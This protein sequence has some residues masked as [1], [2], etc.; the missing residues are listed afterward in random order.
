MDTLLNALIKNTKLA[1]ILIG[2]F[3]IV[4]GASGGFTKL[5]LT[6]A[7]VAW[8]VALFLMGM[9]VAGFGALLIWRT[10]HETADVESIKNAYALKIIWPMVGA[11]VEGHVT[12]KGTFRELP[13]KDS[14]WVLEKSLATGLYYFS[15]NP[16]FDDENRQWNADYTVGGGPG[17]ERLLCV[18]AVGKPGKVLAEYYSK[19]IKDTGQRIGVQD[20][21]ADIVILDSVRLK[22]K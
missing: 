16:I 6:I 19:V 8:R 3:L 12:V 15:R 2:L 10:G 5:S 4:M 9:I 1:I 13:P 17:S 21:P 18:V 14:I 20:I 11:D 7:G 22:H